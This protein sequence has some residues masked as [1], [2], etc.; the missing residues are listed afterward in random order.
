MA[1]E[2]KQTEVAPDFAT[3]E[4]AE[5]KMSE[6]KIAD[7]LLQALAG[8]EDI[9]SAAVEIEVDH[10]GMVRL[11][12]QV[13]T[14]AAKELAEGITRNVPGVHRVENNLIAMAPPPLSDFP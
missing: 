12:G 9:N 11:S 14:E 8:A 2:N 4:Q 10:K 5:A 13:D 7:A 1:D 3:S 6:S